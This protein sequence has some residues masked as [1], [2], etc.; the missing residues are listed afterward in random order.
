MAAGELVA[1][2]ERGA[3]GAEPGR[4]SE[5]RQYGDDGAQREAERVQAG[6]VGDGG[7]GQEPAPTMFAKRG[8]RAS[9]S[10][11]SPKRG[12]STSK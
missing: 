1:E 12:C 10:G 7:G 11:P 6:H 4:R 3:A 8:G 9:S 5:E 2:L